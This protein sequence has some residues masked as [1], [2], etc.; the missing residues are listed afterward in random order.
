ME[1]T[2]LRSSVYWPVTSQRMSS[3]VADCCTHYPPTGC[4]PRVCLRGNVFIEAL[5][6]SGSICHNNKGTPDLICEILV[7]V[8]A[9]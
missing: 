4:L 8:R 1:N 2:F 6:S 7:L 9:S 5:P 3:L